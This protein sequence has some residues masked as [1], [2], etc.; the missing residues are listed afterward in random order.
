MTTLKGVVDIVE[1]KQK[2][3]EPV[4][5]AM[6]TD[7]LTLAADFIPGLK[8]ALTDDPSWYFRIEWP[9]IL[10]RE[11]ASYQTMWLNLLNRGAVSVETFMQKV[12]PVPDTGEEMDRIT[13][14]MSD[15][16]SS[17]ILANQLGAIAHMTLNKSLGIP[18]WG[19]V[20]PKVNLKGELAPQEV[21]NMAHNYNWDQGPYGDEI[22]PAGYDGTRGND[23]FLNGNMINDNK[24]SDIPNYQ[25]PQQ[26]NPQ[27]TP[28]Q[29]QGQT[30]SQPGSG[31]P[32][33]SPAGAV[34]M[35]AQNHGR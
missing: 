24:P 30:A 23:A 13:D 16:I 3:W 31:A 26:A 32:A 20:I 34:A 8:E 22:G 21:G 18:P 6:F 4:L 17:A 5:T 25:H 11:D 19:Y 9:S 10:R 15:P 35:N 27:L 28:D 14:E 7:A 1:S 12:L 29:N 2:R 33:V